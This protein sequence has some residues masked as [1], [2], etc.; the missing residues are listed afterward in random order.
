MQAGDPLNATRVC[1]H[2]EYAL[3]LMRILFIEFINDHINKLPDSEKR[4]RYWIDIFGKACQNEKAFLDLA[5]EDHKYDV[6]RDGQYKIR[7]YGRD[8][9]Y[10]VPGEGGRVFALQEDPDE[11]WTVRDSATAYT[12]R[13]LVNSTDSGN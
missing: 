8:S 10:L 12:S 1:T 7:S 5:Y 2:H 3:H 13:S 9:V 6:I 4:W 11:N